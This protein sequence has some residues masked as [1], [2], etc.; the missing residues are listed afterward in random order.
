MCVYVS[1]HVCADGKPFL[2]QDE[3]T[4]IWL[5]AIPEMVVQDEHVSWGFFDINLNPD[6]SFSG[7]NSW[8]GTVLFFCQHQTPY[9][10]ST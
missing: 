5:D 6:F 1:V 9:T 4:K 2:Q 10:T 8:R 3:A 7:Q